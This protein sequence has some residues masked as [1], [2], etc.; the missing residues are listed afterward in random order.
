MA[1]PSVYSA[2]LLRRICERLSEGVP[3]TVIC[4]ALRDEGIQLAPRTVRDWQA[5]ES[6]REANEAIE[7]ARDEGEYAIAERIRK[8]ALGEEGY[9]TGDLLR[10]KL[11]VE[12]ELKLQ[13]K[14]NP[15]RWGER[16]AREISGPGGGPVQTVTRIELVNLDDN[17]TDRT[18]A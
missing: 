5:D 12:S 13:A 14:F 4:R 8:T 15:K 9:S 3:L 2:E 17:G 7:D 18:P 10:D 11:V 6:K 16:I 1:R